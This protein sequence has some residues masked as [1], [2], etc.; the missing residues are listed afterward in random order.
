MNPPLTDSQIALIRLLQEEFP[1]C[2]RPF[3]VLGDALGVSTEQVLEMTRELQRQGRLKRIAAALYH[4]SVGYTVNSML[5][6]DVP[7]DRVSEAAA[8]VTEFPEVTHCYVRSRRPE[9]DYNLYTMVH[10]RS[11]ARFLKLLEE[12]EHR[13]R[14]VR[15][16]SLRSLSEL[17]KT[18]MKYF[19]EESGDLV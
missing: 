2:E 17:K 10:E 3:D 16:A 8:A 6:W 12:M 1:L 7:E 13:I 9:F 19:T 4:R 11:E 14:P 5:V 15:Y 18:G